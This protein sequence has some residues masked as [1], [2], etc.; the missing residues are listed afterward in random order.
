MTKGPRMRLA[1]AALLFLATACGGDSSSPSDPDPGEPGL[2]HLTVTTETTGS[3]VDP[4]GYLLTVGAVERSLSVSGTTTIAD[5]PQGDA[6]LTFS[7]LASNCDPLGDLSSQVTIPRDDT[8]YVNFSVACVTVT[9][10]RLLASR[11][12]PS[13]VSFTIVSMNPDGTDERTITGPSPTEVFLFPVASPDGE[14]IYVHTT[15][16]D[17]VSGW[18]IVEMSADGTGLR[19]IVSDVSAL[20]RAA[21]SPDG[22]RIAYVSESS[23]S[24]TILSLE[25]GEIVDLGIFGERLAWS[26][27]GTELAYQSVSG[28]PTD[29]LVVGVDGEGPVNLTETPEVRE[30]DPAWSPDGSRI[31]FLVDDVGAIDVHVMDAD[32]SNRENL[33]NM[34]SYFE[35]PTWSADG[36]RIIVSHANPALNIVEIDASG[37]PPVPVT[38]SDDVAYSGVTHV[39]PFTP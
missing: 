39:P 10:D 6:M 12:V 13:T 33:T 29:I 27:D 18:G 2:G 26:P 32:G 36:E 4:D 1:A 15:W 3:P 16:P 38:S 37:G 25:G 23:G 28:G 14:R 9:S 34:G 8:V 7:G 22:S 35:L 20:T 19:R 11:E 5:L 31:A 30:E 24:L 17:D 21:V